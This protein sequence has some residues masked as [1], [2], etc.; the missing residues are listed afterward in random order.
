MK[1]DIS[2][3]EVRYVRINNDHQS[4]LIL[5]ISSI[6]TNSHQCFEKLVRKTISF[7]TEELSSHIEQSFYRHRKGIGGAMSMGVTALYDM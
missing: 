3:A 1:V 4:A 7:W 6:A 2:L 5:H